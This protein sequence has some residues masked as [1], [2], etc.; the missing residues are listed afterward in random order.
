MST[1]E[2]WEKIYTTKTP[3]EVSWTQ[4]TPTTSLD[5]IAKYN[6][7]KDAKIIDIGGGDSLLADHLIAL[8]YADITVLDI[9]E[10]AIERAKTR[11]G[12]KANNVTWIVQDITEFT[13]TENYDLWH[14]REVFH[15]LTTKADIDFY[16]NTVQKWANHIVL[17][18][19]S[20]EGPIKCSGLEIAQYNEQT[21]RD[22]FCPMF[23]LLE[24]FYVDHTTP[25]DT[26]QNFVFARLSKEKV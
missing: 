16:I 10:A 20:T 24:C 6:L 7:P 15:F 19:F 4:E 17:G 18:T 13:P 12:E 14:D 22:T 23:T 9:S 3:Q 1:K 8:G 11:L 25:F 26:T 2:H 5:L 21:I